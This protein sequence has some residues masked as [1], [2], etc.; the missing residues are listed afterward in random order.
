M[1]AFA[2]ILEPPFSSKDG[3]V[4]HHSWFYVAHEDSVRSSPGFTS[5]NG[6]GFLYGKLFRTE[7]VAQKFI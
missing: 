3:G 2:R 5:G 7:E 1:P 4:K 6:S